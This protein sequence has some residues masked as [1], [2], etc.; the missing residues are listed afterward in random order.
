MQGAFSIWIASAVAFG[1]MSSPDPSNSVRRGKASVTDTVIFRIESLNVM[2][3]SQNAVTRR[4]IFN[5][6]CKTVIPTPQHSRSLE[7]SVSG[8]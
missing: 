4:C 1:S 6:V 8:P 2:T 5:G 7:P 3:Q